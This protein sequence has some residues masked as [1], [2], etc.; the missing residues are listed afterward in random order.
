MQ[1]IQ[2]SKAAKLAS[3]T[4]IHKQFVLLTQWNE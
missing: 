4:Q 3:H 2:A 1:G